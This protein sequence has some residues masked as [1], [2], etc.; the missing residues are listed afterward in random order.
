MK[1]ETSPDSS[2]A[3]TGH[4]LQLA[5]TIKILQNDG[6]TENLVP[7]FDHF[8][9]HSREYLIYAGDIT[10][11]HVIRFE[12]TSDPDDQ[13]ILYAISDNKQKLKGLYIDSYGL[14]HDDLS[15]PM[16]KALSVCPHETYL[17]S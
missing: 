11:D 8:E 1:N 16:I 7:R 3:G 17:Q 2:K 14:Y 15:Q 12:N 5:P 13:S 9:C 4:M 6:Y 10:V